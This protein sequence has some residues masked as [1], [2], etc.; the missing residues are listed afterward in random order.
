MYT[1]HAELAPLFF[2]NEVVLSG[3]GEN[4]ASSSKLQL[5]CWSSAGCLIVAIDFAAHE[6]GVPYR[7]LAG[8]SVLHSASNDS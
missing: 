7:V 8:P 3:A 5:L 1:R 6:L 4:K 2:E